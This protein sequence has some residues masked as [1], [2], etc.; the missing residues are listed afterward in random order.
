[1]E[2]IIVLEKTKVYLD[3]C[4]YNRPFDDQSQL[5]INMET[6]AKLSIQQD[7]RENNIC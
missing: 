4:C 5:I 3:N 2:E 6:M 1:M 7:I